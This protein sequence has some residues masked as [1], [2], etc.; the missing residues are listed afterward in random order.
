MITEK[1]KKKLLLVKYGLSTIEELQRQTKRYASTKELQENICLDGSIYVIKLVPIKLRPKLKNFIIKDNASMFAFLNEIEKYHDYSELW[2]C[3]DE[4]TDGLPVHGRFAIDQTGQYLELVQA[5][6]ARRLDNI[7]NYPHLRAY[8]LSWG[9]HYNIEGDFPIDNVAID[10][11]RQRDFIDDFVFDLHEIGIT[12]VSLEFRAYKE[13]I[14]FTDW[15]TS[16]DYRVLNL[17][18]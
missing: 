1:W 3:K 4:C 15:D 11:E 8:R 9:W 12:N 16:D 18:W 17:L 6:T 14:V 10:I 7:D 5:D 13:R 2:C